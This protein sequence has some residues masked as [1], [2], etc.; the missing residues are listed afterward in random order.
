M[1]TLTLDNLDIVNADLYASQGYPWEAWDILRREAPVYWYDRPGIDPFWVISKHDDILAVSREPEIFANN[2]RLIIYPKSSD[3]GDSETMPERHLL[4]MDPP[5]HGKYRNLVN[6]R[7]TPR[8]LDL[9]EPHIEAVADEVVERVVT[10]LLDETSTKE[11][12]E[13][14]TELSARLPLAVICDMLGVPADHW[15]RVMRWTNE[16]IGAGDPEYQAGRSRADTVRDAQKEMFAYFGEL[17]AERRAEPREDIISLLLAAE[18]EGEPLS[19]FEIL[20]YCF[21][22]ILGGNET[23]RNATS[24]GMAALIEHPDQLARLQADHTL[25]PTA[26]EEILRW[27]SPIIQFARTATHDTE[28]RGQ[29]IEAGQNVGLYYAS[30]NRD[31]DV[32]DDPYRFDVGRDPNEHLAFGGYGEH[33]CLGANLARVEL[34]V[35]FR[36]LLERFTDYEL[37]GDVERLRSGFVGGIK[38]LP[39][40]FRVV[41]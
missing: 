26:V 4:N 11:S 25:L 36:Q 17:V 22:L 39:V 27:T 33:F 16:T 37:T 13:F 6:R 23:T 7:F 12:V 35:V 28:V 38:H 19:D 30:A 3:E 34:R 1:T 5:E 29:R 32:F 24:G 18:I 10:A 9:V 31:E 20:W 40:R 15:D 8:A 14:V 21:L 2:P 41:A